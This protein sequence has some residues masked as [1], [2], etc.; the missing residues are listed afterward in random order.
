MNRSLALIGLGVLLLAGSAALADMGGSTI[1]FNFPGKLLTWDP[2]NLKQYVGPEAGQFWTWKASGDHHDTG[3]A[4][5][6]SVMD[7]AFDTN[8]RLFAVNSWDNV[9]GDAGSF[10][11]VDPDTAEVL[12]KTCTYLNLATADPADTV[13]I[14]TKVNA[15]SNFGPGKFY[16][17]VD[18]GSQSAAGN[19]HLL[20]WTWDGANL[21]GYD[22]GAYHDA[23]AEPQFISYRSNGTSNGTNWNF[24]STGDL[25]QWNNTL[26]ATMT[27]TDADNAA[28][29][30][31]VLVTVAPSNA[32]VDFVAELDPWSH[33]NIND[34]SNVNGG[35]KFDA[36][37]NWGDNVGMIRDDGY[38]I[39]WD[40][41]NLI[42]SGIDV[43]CT[44]I[45]G[46]TV[47]PVPVPAPGAAILGL[48]GLGM[49]KFIARRSRKVQ[50]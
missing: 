6:G 12:F 29:I 4:G 30:R 11:Q 3:A 18:G 36:L 17:A 46:G 10:W 5:T 22:R 49:V 19:G 26:Y 43:G 21:A 41:A 24:V 39:Y 9:V 20:E 15:L 44:D 48:L 47:E 35:H 34:H 28:E 50:A 7:L 38:L 45:V 8:G 40:G 42:N 37:V 1:Y 27:I 33:A 16:A 13:K 2:V 31:Y 32:E 23:D 14:P 25:W